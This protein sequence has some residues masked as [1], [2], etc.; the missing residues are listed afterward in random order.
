MTSTYTLLI[1]EKPDA[2]RRISEAIADT[3]PKTIKKRGIAYYDF[4]VQGKRHICVPAAGHLFI[5]T[6]SK[7]NNP[8]GWN[9]PV[10]NLEWVPTYTKKVTA[11]TQNYFK[12]IQELS[13]NASDFIDA[14]D[15]DTE[16][17]V[18]LFNILRFICNVKDAKRMKFSTLTRD[19]LRE[20]YQ[21]MS[22]TILHS[23]LES[24]LTRHELDALW[25]LNLTRALTL[26]LKNQVNRGFTLLSTGRV[27]GPT[28]AIL[29]KKERQ[30]RKFK[31][32][33]F[34]Q[35]VSKVKVGNS[36]L[37]A[38]YKKE[39]IWDNG[40]A[41]AIFYSC[42]DR[43]ATVIDIKKQHYTQ[44]PPVPF[45]TTALQSEAYRQF[46]YSPK[47]TLQIAENLYQ[48]GIISYPR[49]SSQKLPPIIKYKKILEAISTLTPYTFLVVKLLNKTTLVPNQGKLTD[50]AH[51]AIYP[52]FEVSDLKKLNSY[53]KNIY[54]L[55]I[56]RFLSVFGSPMLRE[57][58]K[59]FL[60]INDNI[61]L[62]KGNRTIDPGWT[63]FYEKYS[64]PEER[65]LPDFNIGQELKI[66]ELNILSKETQSP[67][68]YNQGTIL[69]IM[70]TKNLGT[71]S[72]RANILQTLYD[73]HYIQGESICVTE[74]GEIVINVLE[75]FCSIISS[76]KLTQKFEEEMDRVYKGEK[77]R[78]TVI[79]EAQHLLTT[80]L[81][82]FKKNET[83][84]GQK[85][86]KG[87]AESQQ[88]Q[89]EFGICPTC[90]ND[91]KLVRS[92]R[93][94]L[95]FMGCDGYPKCTNSYPLPH[96]AQIETT[97]RV[98]DKCSTP[99]VRIIRKGQRTYEMCIDV[100]CETK[101][102]GGKI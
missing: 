48:R 5:L 40:E 20:S 74:L 53:Q 23:T 64:P 73:R 62:L 10:F 7:E 63:I 82:D 32:K 85:L 66:H 46:K 101:K 4:T 1:A 98:C 69:K 93:T 91:L 6:P 12:N 33:P 21:T 16:G 47:Q 2:A 102:K 90:G 11:W 24:G 75:E 79:N 56:R 65:A 76:E 88:K 41:K 87:L 30:I 9:Y 39:K 86:L 52:T 51:P 31:P 89:P 45:N 8:K 13:Q 18:L 95:I 3:K 37:D 97:G 25:G 96:N 60:T 100:D 84:I 55:I 70:E 92:K 22:P 14:A 99:I 94:N 83:Q 35:L 67:P 68:R 15:V 57:S 27:Q 71:R 49:S 50:P 19:E 42:K 78:R 80:V 34:W 28:L 44:P 81:N 26:A 58:N 77:K 43:T 61:F 17:E 59:V 54:D 38:I 36:D 72:T 29:L